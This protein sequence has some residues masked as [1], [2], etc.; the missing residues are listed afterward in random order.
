MN[1]VHTPPEIVEEILQKLSIESVIRLKSVCKSWNSLISD[2]IF[3]KRRR[4]KLSS[5]RILISSPSGCQSFNCENGSI[6]RL[7]RCPAPAKIVG[8]SNGLVCV[9]R[10]NCRDFVMWNPT[11]NDYS[12]TLPNPELIP[13]DDSFVYGFGFDSSSD[14]Y[15]I[16]VLAHCENKSGIAIQVFSLRKNAWKTIPSLKNHSALDFNPPCHGGITCNG[17]LHWR[18]STERLLGFNLQK[19]KAKAMLLPPGSRPLP[20]SSRIGVIDG[21]L[22]LSFTKSSCIQLWVR[23]EYR[24]SNSWQKLF[25]TPSVFPQ[26]WWEIVRNPHELVPL[27][28]TKSGK[29]FSLRD[30]MELMKVRCKDNRIQKLQVDIE[31]GGDGLGKSEAI[32]YEQTLESPLDYI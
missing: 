11:T 26:K 15:I 17:D 6:R 2:R 13:L 4:S 3:K 28:K 24:E 7:I 32:V 21:C 12:W 16:V 14:D 18:K 27:F 9:A 1:Q 20:P 22:C 31:F 30:G 10:D 5:Q 23:K 25:E 8:C 29:V 19:K